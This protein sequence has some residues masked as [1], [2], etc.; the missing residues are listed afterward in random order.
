MDT[1]QD[2]TVDHSILPESFEL[3]SPQPVKPLQVGAQM[4]YEMHLK[5]EGEKSVFLLDVDVPLNW[6]YSF[7]SHRISLNSGESATVFLYLTSPE[8]IP[9]M[10]YTARV[11]VTSIETSNLK[12]ALDLTASSKSELVVDQLLVKCDGEEVVLEA[13]ISN[14]GSVDVDNARIQFF[15][16]SPPMNDLLG[17]NVIS[18]PSRGTI[19][20]SMHCICPQGLYAFRVIIDPENLISESCESNNVLS[21]EYLLDRTPPEAEINFDL[22]SQNLV[23]RGI[24]NLDSLV[25]VSITESS[26][27]GRIITTCILTDDAGNTTELRMEIKNTAHEIRAEIL[28]LRYNS[29]EA[30]LPRNSFKIEYVVKDG[31]IIML[32]QSLIIG[33][34]K[35]HLIYNESTNRTRVVNETQEALE[36]LYFLSIR[37]EKGSL[38][39]QV[40]EVRRIS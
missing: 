1:D 4:T 15:N 36:G 9:L 40:T 30:N 20:T 33:D 28:S 11:E 12:T 38:Q 5:N 18:V 32:N 39:C 23:V 22:E 37:T 8:D 16:C 26:E 2:G 25:E 29:I 34:K 13:S 31:E 10:D 6:V 17:E 7:S 19:I 21:I 27:K 24:D 3:T 35:F 14:L